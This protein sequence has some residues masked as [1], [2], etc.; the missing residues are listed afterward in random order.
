[1]LAVTEGG[2]GVRESEKRKAKYEI[3]SPECEMRNTKSTA[4][5]YGRKWDTIFCA[6]M[7]H[8]RAIHCLYVRYRSKRERIGTS[9][10]ILIVK[11]KF[12]IML[13]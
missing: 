8:R 3:R 12:Y 11:N 4:R 1:M 5:S 2:C 7:L 13:I 6:E 10:K 9:A